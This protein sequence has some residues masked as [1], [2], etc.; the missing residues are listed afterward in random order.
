MKSSV[1]REETGAGTRS[2][3]RSNPDGYHDIDIADAGC[4]PPTPVA[5]PKSQLTFSKGPKSK[6]LC[7][8]PTEHPFRRC[9]ERTTSQL[10]QIRR[11]L[12]FPLPNVTSCWSTLKANLKRLTD[13]RFYR[14]RRLRCAHFTTRI[15]QKSLANDALDRYRYGIVQ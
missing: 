4:L 14:G 13:L 1:S 11:A 2:S 10:D 3:L 9:H 6:D 12:W 5:K 7:P 8:A 15:V